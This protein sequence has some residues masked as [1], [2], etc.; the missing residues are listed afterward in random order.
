MAI[1]FYATSA[2]APTSGYASLI[3]ADNPFLYWR[4]G[5]TSG[6]TAVD[7]SGNNRSGTYAS[8][9]TLGAASSLSGDS[10]PAISQEGSG[11]VYSNNSFLAAS[12][13]TFGIRF[14]STKTTLGLV[15][16]AGSQTTSG[17]FAPSL[18]VDGTGKLVFYTYFSGE[19]RVTS[20]NAYNDGA[21]HSVVCQ[22]SSAGMKLFVDGFKVASASNTSTVGFTGYWIA[23]FSN[24]VPASFNGNLDEFFVNHTALSETRIQEYHAAA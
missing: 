7:S 22:M 17:S 19:I 8:G 21:W 3:L 4:L 16:F 6:T 13:F 11:K 14:K 2:P 10:N 5:E 24:R 20:P 15:D 23:G 1:G 9:V 18:Y 12:V